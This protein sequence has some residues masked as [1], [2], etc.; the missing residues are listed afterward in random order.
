MGYIDAHS[1]V[2]TPDTTAYPLDAGYTPADMAPP[3]FTADE[4][5]A[6]ANPCGV[7]RVVLIQMSFYG[8]DNSYMLSE[9]ARRPAAF[10][11]VAIVDHTRKD[12]GE[13][14]ARLRE[15]GVR[16]FRVYQ[17]GEFGAQPLDEG[18]RD[19]CGLAGELGMAICPLLDVELLPATARAAAAF[20]N[21]TFVV[22][23]L[24]RIGCG[25]PIE[26]AH[27]AALCELATFPNCN[28]KV[29]AFYA[30]GG[31]KA[32]YDDLVPVVQQVYEA[33]G[34]DRLLWATDCPYQVVS[35]T[36]EASIAFV[37][38]RLPFLSDEGRDA[39]LGRTAE[40][41]FFGG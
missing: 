5:L 27:I 34:A 15:R 37:R 28:V 19:I 17:C 35:E 3:S 26:A 7:R 13:E 10:R 21:T 1:H 12:L 4:L 22:D 29:S 2:W 36:Y 24:A 6:Q 20:P 9:I 8:F 18:Y 11:G 39:I 30:L 14:M 31:G 40:R 33:F 25:R 41:I 23:H 32:P 16:S 38:D